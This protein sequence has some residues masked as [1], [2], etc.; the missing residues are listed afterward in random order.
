MAT[1]LVFHYNLVPTVCVWDR[2]CNAAKRY[3]GGRQGN[4]TPAAQCVDFQTQQSC[5]CP[6]VFLIAGFNK[7]GFDFREGDTHDS[8]SEP[9]N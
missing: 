9:T 7:C 2:Y 6:A 1:W 8:L 3:K 4:V 5:F